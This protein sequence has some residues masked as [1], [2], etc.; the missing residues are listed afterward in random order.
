MLVDSNLHSC[1]I[2]Q[3]NSYCVEDLYKVLILPYF[4]PIFIETNCALLISLLFHRILVGRPYFQ[5]HP[6][7]ISFCKGWPKLCSFFIFNEITISTTITHTILS[8]QR[9]CMGIIIWTKPDSHGRVKLKIL[10]L[11]L[12][13]ENFHFEVVWAL[14]YGSLKNDRWM[15]GEPFYDTVVFKLDIVGFPDDFF[16]FV[17]V[18]GGLLL[19]KIGGLVFPFGR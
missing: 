4:L 14:K 19:E 9:N 16:E 7:Q 12:C 1:I 8:S 6:N 3:W 18:F 2:E 10:V 11:F 5:F 15:P 13:L 17:E